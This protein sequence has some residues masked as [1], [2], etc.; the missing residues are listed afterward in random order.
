[1]V[2]TTSMCVRLVMVARVLIGYTTTVNVS[3]NANGSRT[4]GG[5]LDPLC[6]R[7]RLWDRARDEDAPSAAGADGGWPAGARGGLSMRL[8]AL[9]EELV[10]L[11]TE[12]PRHQLVVW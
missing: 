6:D 4:Q 2:P 10:Q 1:M 12:L 8:E 7:R 11:H 9:R 3:G 5:T